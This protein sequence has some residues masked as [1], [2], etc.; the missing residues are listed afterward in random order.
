MQL[1]RAAE[2]VPPGG[3][4]PEDSFLLDDNRYIAD[5]LY[6]FR[7]GWNSAQ[8]CSS[9]AGALGK[10]MG[11]GTAGAAQLAGD[12]LPDS[13]AG[14]VSCCLS[15]AKKNRDREKAR[16][17]AGSHLLCVNRSVATRKIL[18]LCTSKSC[19]RPAC[20]CV[21]VCFCS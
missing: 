13:H 8:G 10:R 17:P 6:D 3:P 9:L 7:W 1:P 21:H 11:H 14:Q 12:G 18:P 5:V 2:G 15:D 16:P 4:A 20:A 19:C